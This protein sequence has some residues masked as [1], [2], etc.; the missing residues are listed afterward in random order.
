MMKDDVLCQGYKVRVSGI[1]ALAVVRYYNPGASGTIYGEPWSFATLQAPDP[2]EIEYELYD[3]RGY[4][5]L[6]L[7]DKLRDRRVEDDVTEQVLAE[8]KSVDYV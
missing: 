5:A 8:L 6:W 3:R 7:E 2:E 4:R 1:P